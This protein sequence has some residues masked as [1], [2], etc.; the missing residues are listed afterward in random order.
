[1]TARHVE[2]EDDLITRG[3]GGNG[4]GNDEFLI[5]VICFLLFKSIHK[6]FYRI[7]MN[8]DFCTLARSFCAR[9]EP[10]C[11]KSSQVPL[12]EAFTHR[13]WVFQS[14]LIVPNREILVNNLAQQSITPN[15]Y[16]FGMNSLSCAPEGDDGIKPG[17]RNYRL[18]IALQWSLIQR[19]GR[20]VVQIWAEPFFHGEEVHAFAPVVIE[21]LIAA[22]LSHPE[23]FGLGMGKIKAAHAAGRPHGAAFGQLDAGLLFHVQ[24]FPERPLFCVVG[25]GRIAGGG[26]DAAILFLNQLLHGQILIPSISPF[27]ANAPVQIFS[28]SLRQA[29]GQRLGQDGVVIVVSGFELRGQFVHAQ[30]GGDGEQADVILPRLPGSDEIG[31][32][33]LWLAVGLLDLLAQEMEHGQGRMARRIGKDLV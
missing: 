10:F 21:H 33:E 24:Q 15:F 18:R 26:A 29:V 2:S 5:S 20:V 31:Q 23:V 1:M 9:F 7:S 6:N 8:C 30:A 32:A 4:E 16:Q 27:G 22:Q 17:N 12:H 11:G 14:C 19:Y 13:I 3:N 28:K 25:T